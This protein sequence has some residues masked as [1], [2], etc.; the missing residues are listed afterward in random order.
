MM[1]Q[2]SVAKLPTVESWVHTRNF[3]QNPTRKTLPFEFP[4][5]I[6]THAQP[7]YAP[8]RSFTLKQKPRPRKYRHQ[9]PAYL[10]V[11][12]GVSRKGCLSDLTDPVR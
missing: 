9:D 2:V 5:Y 10:D 1:A 7:P 8:P 11:K 3:R 6:N 4:F 12:S